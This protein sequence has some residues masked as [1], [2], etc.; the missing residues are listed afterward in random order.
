MTPPV[1]LV[2][3]AEPDVPTTLPPG[4]AVVV[5]AFLSSGYHVHNDIPAGIA[6]SGHRDVTVAPA[7]GP[8]TAMVRVLADR[9]I[10]FGGLAQRQAPCFGRP[11][12]R[13]R[14]WV[15]AAALKAGG[16]T[17]HFLFLEPARSLDGDY[18][19]LAFG[20]RSGLVDHQRIDL[21]H[22]LERL[23]ILDQDA[24]LRA[25]SD[26]HHDRHRRSE[27]QRAGAGDDQHGDG[28][29][30][31]VG[32]ARLRADRRP[33]LLEVEREVEVLAPIRRDLLVD[34]SC[35][36]IPQAPRIAV[37]ADRSIGRVEGVE[38][39]SAAAHGWASLYGAESPRVAR[40]K[41]RIAEAQ[42]GAG[43]LGVVGRKLTRD[44]GARVLGD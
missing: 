41:I 4:P 42:L 10:D 26:T 12:H 16:K 22:T 39:L 36:T 21:F 23:G 7:L 35:A 33:V 24:R 29:H 43:Q 18:G 34:R 27:A 8:S 40:T 11:D 14:Q 32:Q 44:A 15:L 19:R 31:R 17:Q 30:Q 28:V 13:L 37:R 1:V 25:A 38:L 9:L 6:E 5:P 3:P 2:G 20:Q